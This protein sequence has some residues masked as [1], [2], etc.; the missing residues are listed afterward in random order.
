M[1]S[2]YKSATAKVLIGVAPCG[3][4]MF[5]SEVFEGAISDKKIVQESG[6]IDFIEN[7]D[8]I[9][10]DRGF[11]IEEMVA[12]KGGSL[13]IPPFLGKKTTFTKEETI[14]T[15]IIARARIHIERFNERI[16]NFRI[17]CGIVPL[18]LASL[19]SQIVTFF[20]RGKKNSGS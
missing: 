10:V 13:V 17:I 1:Y 4:C 2:S 6:I 14:Q 18:S 11:T 3:A 19:L 8:Q 12:Q 7:G 15:K 16:K 5:V 9:V 20:R